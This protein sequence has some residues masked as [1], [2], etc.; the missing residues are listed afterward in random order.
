MYFYQSCKLGLGLLINHLYKN[1][2]C[3]P[4][5][6]QWTSANEKRNIQRIEDDEDNGNQTFGS[7]KEISYVCFQ[8]ASYYQGHETGNVEN[9]NRFCWGKNHSQKQNTFSENENQK[10]ETFHG[11]CVCWRW[12]IL[13]R[14]K[15][16]DH[17][18]DWTENTP[19]TQTCTYQTIKNGIKNP[20]FTKKI[21]IVIE[22]EYRNHIERWLIR[23][24]NII[25]Y[26]FFK[27]RII[28]I[29]FELQYT[30]TINYS[31]KNV[32]S[33][34]EIYEVIKDVIKYHRKNVGSVKWWWRGKNANKSIV[35]NRYEDDDNV[36]IELWFM[37]IKYM[38][39]VWKM[40]CGIGKITRSS[41]TSCY[42]VTFQT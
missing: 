9:E 24:D 7:K 16:W 15:N 2:N 26:W 13:C 29:L 30:F 10:P 12:W 32:G 37:I 36:I 31:V 33:D 27:M 11:S 4:K 34:R 23:F 41:W 40:L 42:E 5:P 18:F 14:W 20:T 35:K 19:K 8:S 6:N 28:I 1:D 38:F 17:R 22:M 25:E 21:I 3:D 39:L